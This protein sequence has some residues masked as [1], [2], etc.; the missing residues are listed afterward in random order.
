MRIMFSIVDAHDD[1]A[2]SQTE[3]ED[4]IGR[5]FNVVDENCHDTGNKAE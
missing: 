2:L 5:I 3:V 4:F 1:D